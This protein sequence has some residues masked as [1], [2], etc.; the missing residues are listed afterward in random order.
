M[1]CRYYEPGDQKQ[2]FRLKVETLLDNV[3]LVENLEDKLR[4]MEILLQ[5][6]QERPEK[7]LKE[8]QLTTRLLCELVKRSSPESMKGIRGLKKWIKEHNAMDAARERESP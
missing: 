6:Y 5:K 2:D 4:A 8:L 1:P 7:Y 3:D